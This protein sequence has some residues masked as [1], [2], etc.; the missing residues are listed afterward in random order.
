VTPNGK[1]TIDEESSITTTEESIELKMERLFK[2]VVPE[3][4]DY[5]EYLIEMKGIFKSKKGR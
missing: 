4:K 3:V 1:V 2:E 5:M